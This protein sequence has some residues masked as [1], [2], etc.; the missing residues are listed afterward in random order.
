MKLHSLVVR[1]HSIRGAKNQGNQVSDSFCS[2]TGSTGTL[3]VNICLLNHE[4]LKSYSV[5]YRRTSLTYAEQIYYYSSPHKR[6][7]IFVRD[8]NIPWQNFSVTLQWPP[9]VG[10]FDQTKQNN[11]TYAFQSSPINWQPKSTFHFNYKTKNHT[12]CGRDSVVSKGT[13]YGLYG[14]GFE[15]RWGETFLPHGPPSLP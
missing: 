4:T 13:P 3:R 7:V 10:L 11:I 2:I 14:P 5:T 1:K 15:F 6:R 12:N 9:K 8:D